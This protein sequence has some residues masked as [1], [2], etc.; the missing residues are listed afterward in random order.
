MLTVN[1][2]VR[3]IYC[4]KNYDMQG[5][6][7]TEQLPSNTGKKIRPIIKWT[8]GKYDEYSMFS[9]YIPSYK[10]YYEPFFGGG[11]VFFASQPKGIAFL[12]D[13]SKDLIS[14]YSLIQTAELEQQL[15]VY[16]LAWDEAKLFAIESIPAVLKIFK[17]F[18][19]HEF[20]EAALLQHTQAIV[21]EVK[22][23][24]SYS[25]FRDDFIVDHAKFE[26]KLAH[27]MAD[28]I[29]RISNICT[30][31]KKTF[32]EPELIDHIETGIKSGLYLFLR[33]ISNK[34]ASGSM[35]ISKEKAVA[36]WY[37]IR[38]FCYASMFRFN[39]KGEFN[40]PY[41]GIAYN[42]KDFRQ[43]VNNIFLPGIKNIFANATFYNDD[44]EEFLK[45][46]QPQTGDFI[47]VDPPYDSEFS[48]YDQ[49]AF[50]K[51][52]QIR[53]RNVLIKTPAKWM[54]VIKETDFIRNLYTDHCKMIEFDKT[55]TYNVR[56]RNNRDTKHLIILNYDI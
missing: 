33:S 56:G 36:N 8:G 26:A 34:V 25:L 44:F 37:F 38:E 17:Q 22:L 41:G 10:N 24:H 14:F 31:E 28:K 30:K 50:T 21:K 47:F 45:L 13:K 48:E 52:D 39:A 12:N 3:G 2:R 55:Y 15:L 35:V 51:D 49:S 20:D 18:L 1:H 27:S 32:S 11:G 42:R 6:L 9:K 29:R 43:K 46:T 4:S 54:M 23:I 5:I 19:L 7:F 16:A 40:I 53:L